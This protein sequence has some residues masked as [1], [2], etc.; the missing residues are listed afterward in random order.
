METWIVAAG[1]GLAVGLGLWWALDLWTR[2][3]G[4]PARSVPGV[5]LPAWWRA[6]APLAAWCAALPPARHASRAH[7]RIDV[8]LRQVGWLH[9]LDAPHVLGMQWACAVVMAGVVGALAMWVQ[10]AA[11]ATG[12]AIGAGLIVGHAW[13]RW[14]LAEQI[15]RRQQALAR[16]LPFVLDMITLCVEGGLNLQGGLQQ[17]ADKGADAAMRDE[18]QRTLADIRTGLPRAEALRQ[19]AQRTGVPAM[20]VWVTTLIQAETLGTSLGPLLRTQAEQRRAERFL[21][22]EKRAMQAPVRML[23]PLISCIFPCTFIVLA[24]PIAVKLVEVFA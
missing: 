18:L 2:R 16:A 10:T 9:R 7:R 23:L 22:A 13:P 6:L 4:G 14:W 5:P 8:Q 11:L 24:F 17:A 20:R 3:R 21:L 1:A 19:L 15:R 12:L